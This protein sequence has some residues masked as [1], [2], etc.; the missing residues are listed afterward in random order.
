MA[1]SK[2]ARAAFQASSIKGTAHL[3]SP[4]QEFSPGF[5]PQPPWPRQSLPPAQVWCLAE[6]HAP[7]PAQSFCPLQSFL[8]VLQAPRPRQVF[9]PRQTCGSRNSSASSAAAL[10][11][12]KAVP[13]T[14]PPKAA[15]VNLL[16]SRRDNSEDF[17]ASPR[18]QVSR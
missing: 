8:A 10:A 18:N 2:L 15:I 1:F 9:N 4:L 6:A 17:M 13:A 11:G 5:A 7:V 16:N 3:P 12:P 14:T